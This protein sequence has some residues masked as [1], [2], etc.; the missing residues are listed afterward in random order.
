MQAI[1]ITAFGGPD[2]LKLVDLPV[3]TC[4][5]EQVIISV[6]EHQLLGARDNLR[7]AEEHSQSWS[8]ES[9]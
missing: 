8:A 7:S 1:A 4:G 2:Q 3:P 5:P 9:T 6:Q